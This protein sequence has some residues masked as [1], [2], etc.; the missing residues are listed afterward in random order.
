[1]AVEARSGRPRSVE[2]AGSR[3]QFIYTPCGIYGGR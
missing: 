2:P 3:F 1:L